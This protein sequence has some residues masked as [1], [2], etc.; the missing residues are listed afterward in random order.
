MSPRLISSRRIFICAA[1]FGL[2]L[3]VGCA[4][5]TAKNYYADTSDA[6]QV[7][8][9]EALPLDQAG[10]EQSVQEWASPPAV[11]R[12]PLIS[13]RRAKAAGLTKARAKTPARSDRALSPL[14]APLLTNAAPLATQHLTAQIPA[15]TAMAA[16]RAGMD[17]NVRVRVIEKLDEG[18]RFRTL[19]SVQP[20]RNQDL[21][22]QGG[23]VLIAPKLP[24]AKSVAANC[25]DRTVS[26][27][28]VCGDVGYPENFSGEIRGVTRIVCASGEK[29]DVWM[30]NSCAP[31]HMPVQMDQAPLVARTDALTIIGSDANPAPEITKLTRIDGACGAANKRNL[32][33][34]PAEELC[35]S[36][37]AGAV[38]GNG[39]WHWACSGGNGGRAAVCQALH[40]EDGK[41]AAAH[42]RL[43]ATPPVSGLCVGAA[44]PVS[45]DG[46]VW[47]WTCDGKNG[48]SQAACAAPVG[49]VSEEPKRGAAVVNKITRPVV[50]KN[51]R[52][53]AS[54][55]F[56]ADLPDAVPQ[57]PVE[58]EL[59][60]PALIDP[61]T[62]NAA[63]ASMCGR[64]ANASAVAAPVNDL[65]AKGTPSA[66]LGEG[67]WYWTCSDDDEK[68]ESCVTKMPQL[69]E[70]GPQHG[71]NL[72]EVPM[73]GLCNSGA[74]G[75]V[76]GEGPWKWVCD[77]GSGGTRVQCSAL[78]EAGM[79]PASL[80][81]AASVQM[82]RTDK[83]VRDNVKKVSTQAQSSKRLK[84]STKKVKP[85]AAAASQNPAI[86][87]GQKNVNGVCGE[88]VMTASS[89]KPD[90]GLCHAGE[91]EQLNGN[92]P[93]TWVCRGTGIGLNVTCIT[94]EQA[95]GKLP[96]AIDGVCGA[97]AEN[98]AAAMPVSGLCAAGLSGQ[99]SGAGPWAW[100]C[101]GING[102]LAVTCSAPVEAQS[103]LPILD[104]AKSDALCGKADGGSVSN[105]PV[106]NLCAAG[107]ISNMRGAGPWYWDCVGGNGGVIVGCAAQKADVAKTPVALP[108]AAPM[109]QAP[110]M[111]P[112]P[113]P[114]EQPPLD[115]PVLQLPS[116]DIGPGT[117]DYVPAPPE[118]TLGALKSKQ[119]VAQLV[120]PEYPSIGFASG[121]EALDT[122]SM[123]VVM[124]LGQRLAENPHARVTVTAYADLKASGDARE[125]RRL[126]LA[127]AL[128]VRDILIING[129]TDTQ[130]KIRAQGA[131]VPKGNP[132]RVD[133]ADR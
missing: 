1:I 7:F 57:I 110:V 62:P 61:R 63:L 97:A 40:M 69:A 18:R 119:P 5:A 19:P 2:A 104:A 4:Q 94:Q 98:A 96:S 102:G 129:A 43:A 125:A 80:R 81:G 64:M 124:A 78:P 38:T 76:R 67:P 45:R 92:G 103:R 20:T 9:D 50:A 23:V 25:V 111:L 118:R 11:K 75:P 90:V 35:A 101:G 10:L 89:V 105:Q 116:N 72:R 15:P 56:G 3:A 86:E 31:G 22:E 34:I 87:S 114:M 66:V 122:P 100:T 21:P 133:L 26:W 59:L 106:D 68:A 127:R 74:P 32:K 6:V 117:D 120:D 93:W 54:E 132:D 112:P 14:S 84:K 82:A 48:G 37:D 28:R 46:T 113:P 55:T 91:A 8:I 41:C 16:F 126:S 12:R 115:R 95:Q 52:R 107:V 27:M 99:V 83:N 77:G 123:G 17:D 60:I 53:L 42:G 51:I 33:Q 30:S 71:Q 70:C 73:H 24:G 88:A 65:C 130:I 85:A 121:S 128:V 13:K 29:R 109:L 79:Q 36:G 108:T 47:N 131:N 58:S 49:A 44:S 39:P